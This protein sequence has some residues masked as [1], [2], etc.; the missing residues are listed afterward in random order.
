M[1]YDFEAQDGGDWY[2]VGVVLMQ[3]GSVITQKL[4]RGYEGTFSGTLATIPSTGSYFIRF[5][6]GS[7]DRTGGTVLGAT[8][9]V[10]GF[11]FSAG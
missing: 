9:I 11:S 6:L 4:F 7:Y 10:N 5:F 8:L 3:G 2:E 1:T